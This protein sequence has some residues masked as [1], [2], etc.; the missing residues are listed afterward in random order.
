VDHK[1]GAAIARTTRKNYLTPSISMSYHLLAC[2]MHSHRKQQK[3]KTRRLRRI[4]IKA[5]LDIDDDDE[6]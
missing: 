3:K 6:V 4:P 5:Y 1:A 2:G